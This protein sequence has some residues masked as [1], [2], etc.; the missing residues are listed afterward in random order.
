VL[1]RGAKIRF[2]MVAAPNEKRGAAEADAPYSFSLA[3]PR[4]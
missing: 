3:R 2:D 4:D 1:K